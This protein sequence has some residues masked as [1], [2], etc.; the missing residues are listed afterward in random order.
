MICEQPPTSIRGAE[1]AVHIRDLGDVGNDKELRVQK[2]RIEPCWKRHKMLAEIFLFGGPWAVVPMI[3]NS[4]RYSSLPLI[5]L[6]VIGSPTG[7]DC[8]CITRCNSFRPLPF[9]SQKFAREVLPPKYSFH[10]FRCSPDRGL[11]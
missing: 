4:G 6:A 7:S 11:C 5:S 1:N 2:N 8:E 3:N 10:Q 9:A